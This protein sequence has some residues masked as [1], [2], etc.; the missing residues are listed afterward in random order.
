MY[1]APEFLAIFNEEGVP[2]TL[3]SDAHYPEEC[4]RDR[5]LAIEAARG[6]AAED[7]IR[8]L[9]LLATRDGEFAANAWPSVREATRLIGG[10]ECGSRVLDVVESYTGHGIPFLRALYETGAGAEGLRQRGEGSG[11]RLVL[12]VGV[13]IARVQTR[14]QSGV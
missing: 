4:G 7:L 8:P 14:K 5:D 13:V 9:V 10:L 2:I 12:G 1:P 6:F 3:A 11:Q